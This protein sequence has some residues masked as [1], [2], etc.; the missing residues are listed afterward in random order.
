MLIK[1]LPDVSVLVNTKISKC[2]NKIPVVSD[3]VKKTD[4]DNKIRKYKSISDYNK[5]TKEML[6]A[7]IK[8]KELVK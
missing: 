2:K 7:R 6:D 4:N 8:E 3:L 5:F 1:K